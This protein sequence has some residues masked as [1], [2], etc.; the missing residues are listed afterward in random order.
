MDE[1]SFISQ[2]KCIN[3]ETEAAIIA[4]LQNDNAK[5]GIHN[6]EQER[7]GPYGGGS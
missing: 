6:E 4:I 7:D 1:K 2:R 5:W 3:D